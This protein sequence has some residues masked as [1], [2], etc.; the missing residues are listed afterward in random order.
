MSDQPL[1]QQQIVVAILAG[2]AD[3]TAWTPGMRFR[4]G[5]T[6][7]AKQM[8]EVAVALLGVSISF[9]TLA[10]VGPGLLF[11]IAGVVVLAIPTSFGICRLLGLPKRMAV[12]VACGNS[13]CGN[14]A[15]AA[16]APTIGADGDVAAFIAF[17][18][19][20]GV[21][22]VLGLPFFGA[23]LGLSQLRFGALAGLTVYAVPQVLAAAS[24]IGPAAVQIG[25]LV[26]LARVLMLGP[27]VLVLPMLASRLRDEI[28]EPAPNV[29][30]GDRPKPGHVPVHR[31]VPPF[32]RTTVRC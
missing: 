7:G 21:F 23:A 9:R 22:V 31:M 13:I 10:E 30:A 25:T 18:A 16:V 20:L 19:V 5:I 26:K 4:A 17:T 24:P 27:V 14:S 1:I 12:L 6:F 32:K 15:I 3:R 2:T 28:E 29:T 11:G 8:L